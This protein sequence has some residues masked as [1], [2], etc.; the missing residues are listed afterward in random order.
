HIFE[1]SIA[2]IELMKQDF[3]IINPLDLA[4]V[5]L[6][7]DQKKIAE[8]GLRKKD[9]IFYTPNFITKYLVQQTVGA[10]LE[11]KKEEL[12]AKY[13]T[14][15]L[16]FWQNY[17]Q[18][19]T[20]IKV[21]DPACGSGAFLTAVFDELWKEWKIALT[22]IEKIKDENQGKKAQNDAYSGMFGNIKEETQ[23]DWQI[24]K[25][26]VQNNIFGV[27]L[28]GESV[29]ISKLAMWL[30]TANRFTTLADLSGN[31]KQGNSLISD[32]NID[33]RAFDWQAEF[34]FDFDVIVGNPPYVSANNMDFKQRQYFNQSQNYK[35][36]QG[37]W[38]LFVP[39]FERGLNLLQAKGILSFIVP[40]GLLNQPFATNLR[41]WILSDFSLRSIVDLHEV[42]VFA[43]ATVPTCIPVIFKEPNLF[44]SINI[45]KHKLDGKDH[46]FYVSHQI[47]T[48]KY[49]HTENSM[50]RT[51]KL[52]LSFDLLQKIKNS[53]TVLGELFYVSTGAE[54]HGK[55]QRSEEGLVSGYS[56]FEVLHEK[57][58]VGFKP[59]IE[60]ASI[61]KSRKLGA[62]CYPQIDYYLDYDNNFERM[63]SPKFKELFESP[64][65]IV[66]VL[67]GL[68][69]IL[70]TFDERN[71]FVGH[72][73][74]SI[75]QKSNLPLKHSDYQE[76][77][78]YN[79]K[80]LLA[81]LN[82]QLMHFY[83]MSIYGGF[84]NVYPNYIKSLP[85]PSAISTEI[86]SQMVKKVEILLEL[87]K[88]LAVLS[89][90]FIKVLKAEFALQKPSE[91]L[92][93][94]YNL[95]WTTFVKE[96]KKC[97]SPIP[98][99]KNFEWIEIFEEKRQ[100]ALNYLSQSEDLKKQLDNTIYG[101]Y[102]LSE[103]EIKMVENVQ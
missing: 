53:G 100:D 46:I 73:N 55:E 66:R 92:E 88:N 103:E 38:D 54:I 90:N 95:D 39:F 85:I 36:L 97:K 35:H 84:I 10:F 27:D 99:K 62:Y 63:R 98:V 43:E 71:I 21:L 7:T 69:G 14:E 47:E 76:N 64:K 82:S 79:L 29:E 96:M 13:Q 59:Y 80:V 67:A 31:I 16:E 42:K 57:N 15:N 24:K 18:V 75:I 23:S 28:N 86:E 60:G 20:Q 50:F 68:K 19:L 9:G 45:L 83:Y 5:D 2:D 74:L 58:N 8:V 49:L 32:K 1:Q 37:K 52:D 78:N 22:E 72:G 65:I 81:L 25:T 89:R 3:E 41:Q 34:G 102:N 40:Y 87:H 33:S 30:L 56:K 70:A 4:E 11:Q 48:E 77:T 101:L 93:L 44:K 51:E 12:L 6:Q 94:W 17:T 61:T 26:I 91:R